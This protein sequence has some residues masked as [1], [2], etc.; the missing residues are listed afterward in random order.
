MCY[1]LNEVKQMKIKKFTIKNFRSITDTQTINVRDLTVL[2][3]KNN[4]GKSNILKALDKAM[5]ILMDTTEA[6]NRYGY[7]QY[8][9]NKFNFDKDFPFN[10]KEEESKESL[11]SITFELNSEDRLNIQSL[12]GFDIMDSVTLELKITE[13]GVDKK[14]KYANA[15]IVNLIRSDPTNSNKVFKYITSHLDY[16]Y[17]PAVRTENKTLEII[18]RLASES[19]KSLNSDHEY[20][21]ALSIIE[22]KKQAKL[23]EIAKKVL[24]P[25]KTFIP[26]ISDL[27][28]KL[29]E[30]ETYSKKEY[31]V[32]IN[33]GNMTSL[34]TKGEGIKS[35]FALAMMNETSQHD[36]YRI[37]AIEEPESHLHPEA[38]HQL[39]PVLQSLSES[40]QIFISTH[41]P[42]FIARDNVSS[43]IIINEG[44]AKPAKSIKEIKEVLGVQLSDNLTSADYIIIVEGKDDEQSLNTLLPL[45]SD[46]AKELLHNGKL[47]ITSMG[48]SDNLSAKTNFYQGLVCKYIAIVDNDSAGLNAMNTAISKGYLSPKDIFIVNCKGKRE[49]EFEDVLQKDFYKDILLEYGV[50]LKKDIFNKNRTKKWSDNIQIMFQEQSRLWNDIIKQEIK[51]KISE[52]IVKENTIDCINL[53]CSDFLN[54]LVEYIEKNF[55]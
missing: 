48:G 39:K 13:K 9:A 14:Y 12:I 54:N 18:N 55:N 2:V 46:K 10:L 45:L 40:N 47:L 26:K 44:I 33:D 16:I 35:L 30:S 20:I 32:R 23:D 5:M 52:K 29:K 19:L 22:Q 17:I 36:K 21:K 3:G 53:S 1:N 6:Y 8:Q 49:S 4:E 38:I 28:I 50:T 15:E 43:N 41:N 25:I 34:E 31:D 24:E 51:N 11:I 42:V 7:A 27:Q 37:I